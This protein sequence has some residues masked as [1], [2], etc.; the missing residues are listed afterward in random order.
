MNEDTGFTIDSDA[1]RALNGLASLCGRRPV[2][3]VRAAVRDY[4]VWEAWRRGT[5][6]DGLSR[7]SRR[8]RK[9]AP[10]RSRTKR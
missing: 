6:Y 7:A 9:G 8:R 4:L 5:T 10:A 3:I 2:A 1:L